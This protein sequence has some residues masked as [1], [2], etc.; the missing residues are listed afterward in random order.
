MITAPYKDRIEFW[1]FQH[2]ST[3]FAEAKQLC[4]LILKEKIDSG[5][6]LHVPLMTALHILYGRPFKQRTEVRIPEDIVPQN[7]KNTHEALINMRDKIHA[8]TDVDGPKTTDDDCL[9]KVAV[10]VRNR[11]A[12]FALTMVFPRAVQIE[13]IRDLSDA[14]S[15]KT[16]YH[17]EKIWKR[18]FS[19]KAVKDGNYEVNISKSD[20]AFLKTNSW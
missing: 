13:E 14:L 5:H 10:F 20:D 18:Y 2:A 7:N 11:S 6:P 12:R 1:K 19:G 15:Q 8:H 17:A 3:T 4:E 9:N 16:W